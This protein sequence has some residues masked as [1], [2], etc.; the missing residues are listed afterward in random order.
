MM[1]KKASK[2]TTIRL[3]WNEIETHGAQGEEVER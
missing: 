2:T 1:G 3:T